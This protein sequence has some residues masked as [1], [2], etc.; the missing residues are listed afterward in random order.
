[1][2][3]SVSDEKEKEIEQKESEIFEN[4][5]LLATNEHTLKNAM[6]TGAMGMSQKD[7]Y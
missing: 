7:I 3:Y 4:K 6:I 1:M 5:S 2:K